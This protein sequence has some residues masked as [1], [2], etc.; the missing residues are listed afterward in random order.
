MSAF[1]VKAD[2]LALP[3]K[4]LLVAIKRHAAGYFLLSA[5]DLYLEAI[6][7]SFSY[8]IIDIELVS[9]TPFTI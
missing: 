2:A 6:I 4:C 8:L 1:G 9:D 7:L 5:K 3:S